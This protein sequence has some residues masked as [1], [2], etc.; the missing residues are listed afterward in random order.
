[1]NKG[2][3]LVKIL[4]HKVEVTS[5]VIKVSFPPIAINFSCLFEFPIL[6]KNFQVK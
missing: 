6:N 3:S 5:T 2:I 1:M 4:G